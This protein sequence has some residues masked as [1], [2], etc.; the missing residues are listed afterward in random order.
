MKSQQF[1]FEIRDLISGFVSAFDNVIIKRYD[2]NRVAANSLQV[3]YVYAPKQRVL[4]DLVNKA[5]NITIP[6][7]SISMGGITRSTERVFNK[8]MG[9]TL[10]QAPSATSAMRMPVP[11]DI[12]VNMSVITKFQ[13]DMDQILSNFI[14]FNNP[15]IVIS[16]K[17]P[18]E[19]NLASTYEIRSEVLWSGSINMQY[20]TDQNATDKYRITADTSFTIQGW[21]FPP[22]PA[23]TKNIYY[24]DENLRVNSVLTTYEELSGLTYT[25]PVSTGMI[26]EVETVVASASGGEPPIIIRT[27]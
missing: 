1:Y 25:Y 9:L 5:Q 6:V 24:I 12:T 15:Y 19:F 13:T 18:S 23:P 14:P 7:V 17:I 10:Q 11:V 21:L 27:Y 8:T 4:Y 3:R 26:K 2:A 22:A 20:P 16:W